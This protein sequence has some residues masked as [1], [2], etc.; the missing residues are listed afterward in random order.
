VTYAKGDTVCLTKR[1]MAPRLRNGICSVQEL[2][3]LIV[4]AI[5]DAGDFQVLKLRTKQH[6]S[7]GWEKSFNVQL[8]N[9][10]G[11]V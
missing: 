9:R 4:V 5:K 3:E 11:E 1:A 2:S 7:I 10:G 6:S 8:V